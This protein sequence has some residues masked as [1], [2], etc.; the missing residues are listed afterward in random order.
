MMSTA[1][2]MIMIGMAIA[3]VQ[4]AEIS[5]TTHVSTNLPSELDSKDSVPGGVSEE[6]LV[7]AEHTDSTNFMLIGIVGGVLMLALVGM[8]I[9]MKWSRRDTLPSPT[10]DTKV[11]GSP[12]T[13]TPVE[14]KGIQHT[15]ESIESRITSD[16]KDDTFVDSPHPVQPCN[17][18]EDATMENQQLPQLPEGSDVDDD[19]TEA[20]ENVTVPDQELPSLPSFD[21]SDDDIDE[22]LEDQPLPRLPS[23][24]SLMD[25]DDVFKMHEAESFDEEKETVSASAHQNH[26]HKPNNTSV[27]LRMSAKARQHVNVRNF[28][29]RDF[30]FTTPSPTPTPDRD[31]SKRHV[32]TT[33]RFTEEAF[34]TPSPP[35]HED[36]VFTV[37]TFGMEPDNSRAQ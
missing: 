22:T 31:A 11:L 10:T 4:G 3:L 20:D 25:Y 8:G 36:A 37:S 33:I 27:S 9:A 21:D 17:Q 30:E 29:V 24:T 7:N 1:E 34:N 32:D 14:L 26:H 28:G 16:G 5:T 6:S 23:Q 13:T 19:G 15:M 18:D 2:K 12:S 35:L